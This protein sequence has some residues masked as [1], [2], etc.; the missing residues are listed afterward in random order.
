MDLQSVSRTV[1]A[2]G[3]D[4]AKYVCGISIDGYCPAFLS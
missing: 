3:N 2:K 4:G 1:F